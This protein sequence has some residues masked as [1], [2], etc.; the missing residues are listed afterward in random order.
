MCSTITPLHSPRQQFVQEACALQLAVIACSQPCCKP[1]CPEST[2]RSTCSQS[3]LLMLYFVVASTP[4]SHDWEAPGAPADSPGSSRQ[5]TRN[6]LPAVLAAARLRHSAESPRTPDNL[7]SSRSSRTNTTSDIADRFPPHE[8]AARTAL[9][10]VAAAAWSPAAGWRRCPQA[11]RRRVRMGDWSTRRPPPPMQQGQCTGVYTSEGGD[12]MAI[13]PETLP[14]CPRQPT[15]P[16]AA[17]ADPVETARM[18]PSD[19]LTS[20]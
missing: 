10:S 1:N 20:K 2:C 5:R 9:G 6:P 3:E 11:N 18:I 7:T 16:A 17:T 19:G 4:H 8:I 13:T 15:R 14:R 12:F